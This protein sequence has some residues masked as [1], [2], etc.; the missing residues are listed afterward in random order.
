MMMTNSMMATS[1]TWILGESK[2]AFAL[3]AQAGVTVVS[4]STG[5]CQCTGSLSAA[6]AI[7]IQVA[8][9]H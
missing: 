9:L 8:I 1:M 2:A 5:A 3:Q 4:Y 7:T 6:A